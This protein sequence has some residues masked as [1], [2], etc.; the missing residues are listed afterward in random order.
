MT[1]TKKSL[2]RRISGSILSDLV[3]Y[4]LIGLAIWI[5]WKVNN[6]HLFL[7]NSRDQYWIGVVGGTVMLLLFTYPIRKH[8][9]FARNWGRMYWWFSV[10]MVLG[11]LGP[12]LILIHS[13]F[14]LGSLNGKVAM[15][16]MLVVVLSGI[17]GRFL[18]MRVNRGLHGGRSNLRDL[19]DEAADEGEFAYTKLRFAPS[20][21]EKLD[22]FERREL[23]A[24]NNIRTFLRQVFILPFQ[25]FYVYMWCNHELWCIL[26]TRQYKSKWTN[27]DLWL[28]FRVAR[29]LSYN[30]LNAV[31]KVAQFT[32]FAR[33]L[34]LWHVVHIPFL[35]TL[36]FSVLVHIYSVHVY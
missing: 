36:I 29:K 34:M 16:S 33:L 19:K 10:H 32:A 5:A 24:P 4:F 27:A 35:A 15:W 6:L 13:M 20:V 23:D 17:T 30:Y 26:R 3:V 2:R 8:F 18:L 14:S 11:I 25:E 31:V 1:H 12:S 7:P 9:K 22:A 21:E 28:R